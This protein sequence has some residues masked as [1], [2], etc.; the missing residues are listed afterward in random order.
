MSYRKQL[1]LRFLD[2]GKEIINGSQ[3]TVQDDS[4]LIDRI[5]EIK[6]E[7]QGTNTFFPFTSASVAME[8]TLY[9]ELMVCMLWY[10]LECGLPSMTYGNARKLMELYYEPDANRTLPTCF[11]YREG[12]IYLS[13]VFLSYIN[14]VEPDLPENMEFIFEQEKTVYGNEDILDSMLGLFKDESIQEKNIAI[15]ISGK[16][17]SGRHFFMEQICAKATV[18][19]ILLEAKNHSYTKRDLNELLLATLFYGTFPIVDIE[20]SKQTKLFMQ[21]S[22]MYP[23][24]GIIKEESNEFIEDIGYGI[25]EKK[26]EKPDKYLKLEMIEDCFKENH[27][28]DKLPE[29]VTKEQIASKQ[30]HTGEFLRYIQNICLE[31]ITGNK[32]IREYIYA[33]TS[34][35]LDMLPATRTFEELKLPKVQYDQLKRICHMI[36]AKEDVLQKWGFDKKFSYGNGMSLLFYGSPGTGKTMAAQVLANELGMPLYRVDLSQLISKYIGETQKNMSKIFEEADKCDC[37]L[38]FDEADALFAKRSDVSDAQDRYS[39]AETAYLL[40]R[41]EQYAGV[42]ILA[43]N[44]L[45]NF[46]DAFRRRISYMVHFPL[47]DAKLRYEMWESIYPQEAMIAEDMEYMALSQ[48]F[49]LSGAAIKN[50]ALHGAYMAMSEQNPIGMKHVLEGISNEYSKIGKS[51][52]QGQ[53]ELVNAYMNGN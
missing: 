22:A 12:K 43:T 42:S 15:V 38:L 19:Y 21:L 45:Q 37:I 4:I 40:Q 44:L 35:H 25:I 29:G 3:G 23:F 9:E 16:V 11:H 51:L 27:C 28:E 8:L 53:M 48:A 7:I 18:P 2:I 26:L 13:P 31:I 32:N 46:D 36:A 41:I 33:S 30:M 34:T 39:N 24:I 17:G 5:N 47:P 49:E 50:A 10:H 14:D 52:N 1:K 20:D 6:E